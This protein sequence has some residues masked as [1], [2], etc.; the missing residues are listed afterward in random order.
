MTQVDEQQLPPSDPLEEAAEW[1]VRLRDPGVGIEQ[2]AEFQRWAEADP[3]NTAAYARVSQK[4]SAVGEHA[5]APE[6]MT[7]RQEA[8]QD[9]RDAAR[10]RW[11]TK[12]PP[13]RWRRPAI[14]SA[15]AA[16]LIAGVGLWSWSQS[17]ADIY[18]TAVGQRSTLTLSDGSIVTLDARSR[19]EVKYD[20]GERLIVLDSG[21][22]RFDVAKEAARP[23][24]VKAAN[25][26]VLALGTQFN[27]ELVAHSVLVTLI[28]GRVAVTADERAQNS[29]SES[30]EINLSPGEG[31]EVHL[32][33]KAVRR[34][35]RVDV[36]RITAWQNGRLFLEQETLASAAE[37]VNRYASKQVEVDS[38]AANIVISGVF[39]AGDVQAF[40]EAVTAYFPVKAEEFRGTTVRLSA[41]DP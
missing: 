28:E 32:D 33:R 12:S 2:L 25:Q 31:L 14:A 17:Q 39:K 16:T 4:W 8:L 30:K 13:P 11:D 7:A 1:F 35:P 20:R 26:T 29:V 5:S 40:V 27:V 10:G 6:I 9:A 3:A 41:R 34:L 24:R 23:F 36:N 19:I 15:M 22:A 38:S 21:Q 18:S 37:R